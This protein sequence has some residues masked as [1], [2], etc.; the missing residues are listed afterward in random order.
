M[1]KCLAKRSAAAKGGQAT[2]PGDQSAAGRRQTVLADVARIAA[3]PQR[4]TVPKD[5]AGRGSRSASI[6]AL[7]T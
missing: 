1:A 3:V 6:R 2:E 4:E 5:Q 7:F